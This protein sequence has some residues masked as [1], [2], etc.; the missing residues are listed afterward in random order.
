MLLFLLRKLATGAAVF[1]AV[2]AITFAMMFARG[3]EFIAA[4]VLGASATPEQVH[5]Y[6][7]RTGLLRP[8]PIQYFEWLGQVL[9]GSLG[10]SILTGQPVGAI[11]INAIPVTLSLVLLSLLLTCLLAIPL[12]VA[13]ATRGGAIDR[14]LQGI[15]VLMQ[16]IPGYWL[17]LVLVIVFGVGLRLVPATGFIPLSDSVAGWFSSI[18][19]PSIAIALGSVAFVGTQIRGA[20]VDVLRQEHIR[21]LKSR[22]L[23]DGR[24]LSKYAMRNISAPTLTILSV[25]MIGLI[26]GAI[27]VERIY[28]LPGI[29]TITI[30]SGMRA[31]VPVVLGTVTFSVVLIVGIN[32]VT[33]IVNGLLNPKMRSI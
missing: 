14:L 13:A 7:E 8:I 12:G 20:L 16:A 17:A 19:L 10:D 2:T 9:R 28:A 31:D 27:I 4:Q 30:A 21:T 15:S 1:V 3:G 24:V 26:G 23:T 11:L 5:N 22:G 25:Q 29:G 18:I 32:L 6:A 33:D